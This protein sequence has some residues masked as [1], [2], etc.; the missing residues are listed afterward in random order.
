MMKKSDSDKTLNNGKPPKPGK[1]AKRKFKRSLTMT[2]LP[3]SFFK[4]R[5]LFLFDPKIVLLVD[6]KVSLYPS[7]LTS[8]QHPTSSLQ[9][10]IKRYQPQSS[11]NSDW[12]FQIGKSTCIQDLKPD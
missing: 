5:H 2:S 7:L 3:L 10:V 8:S 1:K 6:G 11:S 4:V 9:G 12:G